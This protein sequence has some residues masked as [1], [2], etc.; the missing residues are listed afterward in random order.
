MANREALRELQTR[1]A[2]R[3]KVARSEG[4][5]VT[6]LAVRTG[7]RNYL[8]PLSQSGEIVPLAQVQAVP[9]VRP[10]FRGVL[11]I[12]GGLYGVVDFARFAANGGAVGPAR[13]GPDASVV[14][15]NSALEVNCA[16]QVDSLL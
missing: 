14:T 16:L 9:Y 13:V 12:R 6:W 2:S 4:A 10:W 11:N 1:L 15:L 8:F 5:S 3:L 7:D